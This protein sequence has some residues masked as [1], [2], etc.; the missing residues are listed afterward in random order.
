MKRA[1]SF[2]RSKKQKDED[3]S[4]LPD[5]ADD[6]ASVADVSDDEE[7]PS[8]RRR[9]T[10][11]TPLD[12]FARKAKKGNKERGKRER[13]QQVLIVDG[14]SVTKVTIVG[15][16]ILSADPPQIFADADIAT[17][18]AVRLARKRTVIWAGPIQERT[19]SR[20][21]LLP[22]GHQRETLANAEALAEAFG[23]EE[24][25]CRIGS[26]GVR[27]QIDHELIAK[28]GR[29]ANRIVPVVGCVGEQDGVWVHIG[30]V[31]TQVAGVVDGVLKRCT[32]LRSLVPD[33][34][35]IGSGIDAL[36]KIYQRAIEQS[37]EEADAASRAG[38]FAAGAIA[39]NITST[40]DSWQSAVEMTTLRR[41][42]WLH[43]PG[44]GDGGLAATLRDEF[45]YAV[46]PVAAQSVERFV[47][48]DPDRPFALTP[49]TNVDA[50]PSIV[51]P[52][53]ML[54]QARRKRDRRK[55]VAVTGG[56]VALCV[57]VFGWAWR[58][59]VSLQEQIT[60]TETELADV[61]TQIEAATAQEVPV[62]IQERQAAQ[63]LMGCDDTLDNGARVGRTPITWD[64]G[65]T[66]L[67]Y[68]VN[69]KTTTEVPPPDSRRL[70]L[71]SG[72]CETFAVHSLR[73][74][75]TEPALTPI[76]V[77]AVA[78]RLNETYEDAGWYWEAR[79]DNS[80]RSSDQQTY[81]LLP[82]SWSATGKL[83]TENWNS[84]VTA[85][86]PWERDGEAVR[87]A[88]EAA[89]E[90]VNWYAPAYT[91]TAA[92]V[93]PLN[94]RVEVEHGSTPSCSPGYEIELRAVLADPA[95]PPVA[96]DADAAEPSTETEAD[97]DAAV[98][99]ET[100]DNDEATQ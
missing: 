28:L 33:D 38:A 58:T 56:I 65:G 44:A 5:A 76:I 4:G 59:G 90:V 61:N 83:K 12:K 93:D 51:P 40:I 97:S 6:A 22:A 86:G 16:Q 78:E 32:E 9:R 15:Q 95:A 87:V 63:T 34:P 21:K 24:W 70:P 75:E 18:R 69:S 39:D 72:L 36:E 47:L 10:P 49:A 30:H 17:E 94:R 57:A 100:S 66:W 8:K 27:P 14:R 88:A 55:V 82:F 79:A 11:K 64:A 74:A 73:V 92:P 96:P 13:R 99:D 68:D 62:A 98:D 52:R 42:L 84:C 77:G 35:G 67:T 89:T 48:S 31:R 71:A 26:V 7:K 3:D 81:Q 46:Q 37:Y 23:D 53:K 43:G 41:R 19:L 91:V 45:D 20:D 54:A 80:S 85:F 1:L 2:K 29:R 25:C 60:E 50:A